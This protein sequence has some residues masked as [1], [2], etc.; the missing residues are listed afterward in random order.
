MQ[1][2]LVWER[3]MCV[4]MFMDGCRMEKKA[5]YLV[6][7]YWKLVLCKKKGK[8]IGMMIGR[9]VINSGKRLL[10]R[11]RAVQAQGRQ[12]H[13]SECLQRASD[14]EA[15]KKS[16]PSEQPPPEIDNFKRNPFFAKYQQK[17]KSVY[18]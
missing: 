2:Q 3:T 12:Y 14:G 7:F 10:V 8:S 6:W 1:I 18:Q 13:F 4:Y 11:N 5:L 17:L 9:F 16:Q 15:N